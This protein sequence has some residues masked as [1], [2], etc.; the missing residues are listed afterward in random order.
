MKHGNWVKTAYM[1][2][3]LS[4]ALILSYVES[5][6]PFSFG[7]PGVKLGLANLAVLLSLYWYGWKEAAAL[8]AMRVLLAGFLCGNLFMIMYSMAGAVCSFAIMQF[9]KKTGKFS[10]TGVSMAGGVCHNAGQAAV[11]FFV[12][13][14]AGVFY[15]V[16]ALMAAGLLTGMLIG[17]AAGEVIRYTGKGFPTF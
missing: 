17:I 5:L 2:V 1:G 3:L 15:Y 11:A 16:P 9:L 6:I 7:V 13:E 4:F 10:I 8:N 14:T 12:T